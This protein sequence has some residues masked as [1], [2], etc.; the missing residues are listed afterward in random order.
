M[1][2]SW[3]IWVAF[4]FCLAVVLAAMGWISWKAL[5]LD[6]AESQARRHEAEARRETALEQEVRL[7]LYRMDNALTPLV[8]RESARPY[9]AYHTFLP[10]DRAFGQMF[11]TFKGP[12]RLAISPLLN[13]TS[14]DVLVHFQFDPEGRLTCPRVP[15]PSKRSLV[16]PEHISP[17]AVREAETR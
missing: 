10:V 14:P 17:E 6:R 1:K 15:D 4:T 5:R 2:R 8:A 7:A 16:V 3:H 9:F 13:E 12:E 11:N